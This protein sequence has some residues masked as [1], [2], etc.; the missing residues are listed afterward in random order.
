MGNPY[1][2]DL[3]IPNSNF[4]VGSKNISIIIQMNVNEWFTEP[5]DYDFASYPA[6]IMMNMPAQMAIKTNGSSVFSAII[7]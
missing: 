3:Y 1:H 7:N 2:I 4:I 5:N 6:M